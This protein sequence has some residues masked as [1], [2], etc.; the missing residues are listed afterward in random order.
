MLD[1]SMVLLVEFSCSVF[2]VAITKTHAGALLDLLANSCMRGID[3]AGK[4]I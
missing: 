3:G 1:A 2:K 4:Q